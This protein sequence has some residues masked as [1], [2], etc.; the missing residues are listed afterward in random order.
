M[1]LCAV[2]TTWAM[3]DQGHQDD[4][5][6]EKSHPA[7]YTPQGSYVEYLI[8]QLRSIVHWCLIPIKKIW[9]STAMLNCRRAS[10]RNGTTVGSSRNP[11]AHLVTRRA[12]IMTHKVFLRCRRLFLQQPQRRSKSQALLWIEMLMLLSLQYTW[13]A[14][15]YKLW[16]CLTHWNAWSEFWGCPWWRGSERCFFFKKKHHSSVSDSQLVPWSTRH[17]HEHLNMTHSLS[18]WSSTCHISRCYHLQSNWWESWVLR[19]LASLNGACEWTNA[20]LVVDQF[21]RFRGEHF[22]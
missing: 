8:I 14:L 21:L 16:G 6:V 7:K 12:I 22:L 10:A 3:V 17:I 20:S 4:S 1:A 13:S 2:S 9:F 15:P 11:W 18:I 19:L 5:L